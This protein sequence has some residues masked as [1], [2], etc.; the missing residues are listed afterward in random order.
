L[1]FCHTPTAAAEATLQPLARFPLDAAIVFSDILVVLEAIGLKVEFREGEGPHVLPP[2]R[3]LEAVKALVRPRAE[4]AL[5]Y[6]LETIQRVKTGLAGSVPLIGFAGSPWTVACYAVEGHGSKT[7]SAIKGMAYREPA[8]LEALL[9]LL[10]DVTVD[11]LN[12]Q[13]EAGA[14]VIMVFDTWG[15]VLTHPLYQQFS[16]RYLM[17]IAAR[18]HR[19]YRGVRIPLIFFTKGGAAWSAD[20]AATGCDAIGLDWTADLGKVRA[21]LEGKIALQGNLDPSVLFSNPECVTREVERVLASYGPYPGHVFN[22]GHGIEPQTPIENVVALVEAV[23]RFRGT[24]SW[25]ST[26]PR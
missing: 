25:T 13:V 15:G 21:E 1:A 18:V 14:D 4:V 5:D 24:D 19:D 7:F 6:V 8:V 26:Q 17:E 16:V 20:L 22:L 23:H 2:V 9:S 10:T 11:Y 3:S 12:A